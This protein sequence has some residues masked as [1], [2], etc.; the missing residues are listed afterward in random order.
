LS[1][2]R[3]DDCREVNSSCKRTPNSQLQIRHQIQTNDQIQTNVHTCIHVRYQPTDLQ[4]K[5]GG[6]ESVGGNNDVWPDSASETALITER[7]IPSH[8]SVGSKE[9]EAVPVQQSEKMQE[10]PPGR[11][12]PRGKSQLHARAQL[13]AS[14][15]LRERESSVQEKVVRREVSSEE[16]GGASSKSTGGAMEASEEGRD[17]GKADA[18]DVAP[19]GERDGATD[20]SVW[21]TSWLWGFSWIGASASPS[22][23]RIPRFSVDGKTFTVDHSPS[24]GENGMSKGAEQ[25][26]PRGQKTPTSQYGSTEEGSLCSTAGSSTATPST[27]PSTGVPFSRNFK[28]V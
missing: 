1:K 21:G 5:D 12:N 23:E 11:D 24:G 17:G 13:I 10:S 16:V 28:L 15:L 9:T 3:R 14:G 6:E 27:M 18:G 19:V 7:N 26:A 4:S 25:Q 22:Q 20:D 8:S 2:S